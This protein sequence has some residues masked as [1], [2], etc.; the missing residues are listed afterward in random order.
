VVSLHDVRACAGLAN[1]ALLV[2]TTHSV[3]A[4]LPNLAVNPC[5]R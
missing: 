5:L 4:V 3:L 2:G 1:A